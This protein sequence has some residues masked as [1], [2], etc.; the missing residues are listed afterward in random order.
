ML[1]RYQKII[2]AYTAHT[3]TLPEGATD[4]GQ[5]PDGYT[6]VAFAGDVPEQPIGIALT[7]VVVT[8]EIEALLRQHSPQ[9]LLLAKRV[10]AGLYINARNH[11]VTGDA[12][13][14]EAWRLAVEAVFFGVS[15]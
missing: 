4:H 3:A 5:M 15:L 1:Y 10:D 14:V 12:R 8:P 11:V 9:F 7:A 6:Y 2:D 13:Q